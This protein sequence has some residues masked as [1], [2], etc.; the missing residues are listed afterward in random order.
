MI[1]RI[2]ITLIL[3]PVLFTFLKAQE[4]APVPPG[5]KLIYEFSHPHNTN[6]WEEVFIQ[7]TVIY[8]IDTL[9]LFNGQTQK[10]DKDEI[11]PSVLP[12]ADD[13]TYL[14]GQSGNL[15]MG[16]IRRGTSTYLLINPY[17]DTLH[18]QVG[19]PVGYYWN[20]RPHIA[21]FDT[22]R[23]QSYFFKKIV[24]SLWDSVITIEWHGRSIEISKHY[25]VI[26]FDGFMDLNCP[27]YYF[28]QINP[29]PRY[30]LSKSVHLAGVSGDHFHEGFGAAFPGDIYKFN[31]GDILMHV[32]RFLVHFS[33][34]SEVF[35]YY[36]ILADSGVINGKY[37]YLAKV[38]HNF[39]PSTPEHAVTTSISFPCTKPGWIESNQKYYFE[40]NEL[41]DL[42]MNDIANK[43]FL[44]VRQPFSYVDGPAIQ[45]E[46]LFDLDS[47]N[48]KV[49]MTAGNYGEGGATINMSYNRGFINQ[50]YW[51]SALDGYR[52][53]W[54]LYCMKRY[55]NP[56]FHFPCV[57]LS[58]N[59]ILS[60]VQNVN[61]YPM[62][63]SDILNIE[64]PTMELFQSPAHLYNSQGGLIKSFSIQ[65]DSHIQL[66][67]EDVP[68]GIYWISVKYNGEWS[69]Q[70]VIKGN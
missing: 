25:G 63:F 23:V 33:Q 29:F 50:E 39:N 64:A 30:Q 46:S 44:N 2:L 19:N 48:G 35:S 55:D 31:V 34:K 9:L 60:L 52:T 42:Y 27:N 59:D 24:G 65:F 70:K 17:G 54:S 1:L 32:R 40:G 67:M 20:A 7:D 38:Y 21:G 22:A 26:Y 10:V 68:Q 12:S 51:S 14:T 43:K 69:Y 61:F 62:P 4:Y 45:F 66:N 53:Q 28:N 15:G 3:L 36:Q 16:Y 41:V 11:C 13:R 56:N 57:P 58:Q 37:V 47:C 18:L 5:V 6:I 49:R 8:G